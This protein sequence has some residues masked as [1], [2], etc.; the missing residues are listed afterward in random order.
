M[1]D[2][3][4]YPLALIA[5]A[6]P[7]LELRSSTTRPACPAAVAADLAGRLAQVLDALAADLGL[8]TAAVPLCTPDELRAIADAGADHP[9]PPVTLVDLVE[10]QVARTPDATAVVDERDRLDLR[11][12]GRAGRALAGPA[13]CA[14]GGPGARSSASPSRA[15]RS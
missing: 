13:R 15:R 10:A 6:G 14:R 2:A 11:R 7:E 12:A 4:H 3:V 5:T 1:H 9:V 8:P